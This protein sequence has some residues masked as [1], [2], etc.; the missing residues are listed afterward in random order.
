MSSR[1]RTLSAVWNPSINNSITLKER[2]DQEYI[3]HSF[4]F[5]NNL[6]N[7][8]QYNN[9]L[10]Y[11]EG[12]TYTEIELTQQYANG[13]DLA[14][15]IQSKINAISTGIASVV[16]NNNTAKFTITNTTNFY[17]KFGDITSNTCYDVLGFNQSNT[18]N[19]TSITSTNKSDL[20]SCKQIYIDIEDDRYKNIK[21]ENYRSYTFVIQNTKSDFGD[22]FEYIEQSI[23]QRC[24]FSNTKKIHINFYNEKYQ[25]INLTNW[26]LT[27]RENEML[28]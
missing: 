9:I 24:L 22:I 14:T 11:Q 23:P 3:L 12:A 15:D 18:D 10:P 4:C 13:Q 6:Y 21:T 28:L 17:L 27:L 5:T 1:I 25:P 2:F 8:N 16:Y 26:C 7:I 19:G 20:V